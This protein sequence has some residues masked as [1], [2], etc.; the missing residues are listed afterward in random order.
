MFLDYGPRTGEFLFDF[1]VKNLTFNARLYGDL[2]ITCFDGNGSQIG[3]DFAPGP[4][5]SRGVMMNYNGPLPFPL[6]SLSIPAEGI[7]RCTIKSYMG[8]IDEIRYTRDSEDLELSCAGDLGSNRVTRA[9][10]IRCLVKASSGT[11]QVQEWS[12]TGTDSHGRL[13]TSP[14]EFTTPDTTWGGQMVISGTVTVRARVNGGELLDRSVPVTVEP[15]DWRDRQPDY[16]F[17]QTPGDS[18]MVIPSRIEWAE[19]LGFASWFRT[20]R[21]GDLPPD[22]TA[23][24]NGGPNDGLDYFADNATI[25]FF[26]FYVLNTPAMTMGSD[27]YRAQDPNA[28]GNVTSGINWC[29]PIVVAREL[30]PR[31]ERHEKEHGRVYE[32][33]LSQK[34]PAAISDL[35]QATSSDVA[36]LYDK[37]TQ[38]WDELDGF[39]R[40]ESLLLHIRPGG[41]VVPNYQGTPCVLKNQRGGELKNAPAR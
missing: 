38:A 11:V 15:R 16:R 9:Q 41:N 1:P 26:G 21:P 32:A 31:V 22:D 25:S 28:T 27:F 2:E 6:E 13:Y 4:I 40:A 12:F 33:A 19:D 34:F 39:A 5:I 29:P 35:E 23:P 36:D 37:Y 18:R 20:E 7:R 8:M 3:S 14:E 17:V 24:V 30:P 10:E